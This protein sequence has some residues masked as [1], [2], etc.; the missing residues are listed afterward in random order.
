M[1]AKEKLKSFKK[2]DFTGY[3]K[4][5]IKYFEAIIESINTRLTSLPG[6]IVSQAIDT[7]YYGIGILAHLSK[8]Y[9]D[10]GFYVET[11]NLLIKK[12]ISKPKA[13]EQGLLTVWTD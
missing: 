4:D 6:Y 9:S 7:D 11:R 12:M 1:D 3:S 8:A 10:C 5:Q 13:L 2:P